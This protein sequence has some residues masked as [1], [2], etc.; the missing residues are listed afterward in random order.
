MP[1][2]NEL[3]RPEGLVE[4]AKLVGGVGSGGNGVVIAWGSYLHA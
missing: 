2:I 3:G 1:V 4:I